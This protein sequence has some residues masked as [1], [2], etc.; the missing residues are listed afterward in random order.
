MKRFFYGT[1][2]GFAL[3][4]AASV[5]GRADGPDVFTPKRL[6]MLDRRGYFTPAF[7]QAVH[8]LVNAKQAVVDAKKE[9]QKLN[10]ELPALQKQAAE[11]SGKVAGLQKQISDL[12]H[13]DESDFAELQKKLGEPSKSD[14]L[15]KLLADWPH[16]AAS[17]FVDLKKRLGAASAQLD[18]QRALSQAYVWAYP[19]NPHQADAQKYL[20]DTLKK[21]ADQAQALA[22]AEAGRA[23]AHAKLVQR[24]QARDLN[25]AEWRDF[26][27]SMSKEDLL[28][29]LGP[30]QSYSLDEW[31]YN[32]AWTENASTHQK[33][34]LVISF[35][36]GRV[37]N[38]SEAGH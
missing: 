1:L 27:L 31:H 6:D 38:V 15:Q 16:L 32:G 9:E 10:D 36:G 12:D 19:A 17:D 11:S 22:D 4:L 2:T 3:L 8:D 5:P 28:K 14:E 33:V 24:A 30:P 18:E 35:N 21:I 34:G 26:L 29:F 23:A 37:V 25:T 13:I 7:K 20:Q